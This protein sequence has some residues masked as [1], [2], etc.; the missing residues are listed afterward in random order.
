MRTKLPSRPANKARN[1]SSRQPARRP[2][3]PT[4]I[5]F[6]PNVRRGTGLK[7]SVDNAGK[8][9]TFFSRFAKVIF[10][11]G[12]RNGPAFKEIEAARTGIRLLDWRFEFSAVPMQVV[13]GRRKTLQRK[14]P[15]PLSR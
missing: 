8:L 15:H 4:K 13:S 3:G 2:L 1:M 14:L 11:S 9:A 7:G 10:L 5:G 12:M 6:N